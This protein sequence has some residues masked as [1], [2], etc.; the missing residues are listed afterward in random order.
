M[1]RF[2]A[3]GETELYKDY[4][5]EDHQ[6]DLEDYQNADK[7]SLEMLA[8][9]SNSNDLTISI[10]KYD[11]NGNG[12]CLIRPK[13]IAKRQYVN[14]DVIAAIREAYGSDAYVKVDSTENNDGSS[15]YYFVTSVYDK[16]QD[17]SY[18]DNEEYGSTAK[19]EIYVNNKEWS[20]TRY[21]PAYYLNAGDVVRLVYAADNTQNPIATNRDELIKIIGEYA[22]EI[23][24]ESS[25]GY[26]ELQAA[27]NKLV[28]LDATSE[29]IE[30][31]K[32]NLINA[33]SATAV[34]ISQG[35][36][37]LLGLDKTAALKA[38][39]TPKNT[40]DKVVWSTDNAGI[41]T[42]DADTGVV[43]GI[44]EGKATITATAGNVSDSIEVAVGKIPAT[45]V[46]I[47]NEDKITI[48]KRF[49]VQ[50]ETE[51]TPADTTDVVRWSSAHQNVFQQ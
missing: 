35:D 39:V 50:L 33:F 15:S 51:V 41:A 20:H 17:D 18:L 13:R 30:T 4:A 5:V 47:K 31:A 46:V 1:E 14:D 38:T 2:E 9:D 6:N 23:W 29:E 45:N 25:V 32:N 42:V 28:D 19:W 34:E 37:Y 48:E 43:K 49:D 36:E 40:K 24:H 3:S 21:V 11:E 22:P 8:D 12:T 26:K 10:E 44:S 16:N 7:L 27:L